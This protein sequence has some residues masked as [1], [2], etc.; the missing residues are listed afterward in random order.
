MS[1][2][3][4]MYKKEVIPKLLEL[5]EYKNIMEV[6]RLNKVVFNISLGE[7]IQNPGKLS[8]ARNM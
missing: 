7:A 1:R 6:P 2:L 3:K 4:E 8:V 5:G